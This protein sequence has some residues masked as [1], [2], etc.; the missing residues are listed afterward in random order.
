MRP[1]AT[2]RAVLGAA[3]TA[4]LVAPAR[5]ASD[6]IAAAT[7]TATGGTVTTKARP[8]PWR[9]GFSDGYAATPWRKMCLAGL[10]AEAAAHR[11]QIAELLVR[12][13]QGNPSTQIS[14]INAL[15]RARCD[16]ILCI[17]SAP[18]ALAA[19][20]ANATAQGIVTVPFNLPVLGGGWS[21]YVATDPTQ[22]GHA[23]GAWLVAALGGRGKIVGLGGVP[24]NPYTAACWQGTRTALQGTAITVQGL[25][26]AG[27]Q[28]DQARAV[29]AGLLGANV[30]IDGIWCD[31]GQDAAGAIEALLAAHRPPVPVTGDDYNGLLKLYATLAARG[32]GFRFGLIAEPTWQS[33]IALRTALTLLA[34]GSVAKRQ[35]VLPALITDANYQQYIRPHLPDEVLVDTALDDATLARIFA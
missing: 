25:A 2:R 31:G 8:G 23:L 33:V 10:Q 26:A 11:P 12:D 5:A 32:A 34:G 15:I 3:A 19:V 21:S 16:A 29:M 30:A 17:P 14:D 20:L 18:D 7:I 24:A 6:P 22:K 35:M 9:I 4:L 13:G 28:R 1:T 27:W